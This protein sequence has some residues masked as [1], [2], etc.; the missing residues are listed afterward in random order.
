MAR[1]YLDHASSSPLRPVALEA[2]LPYLR[3]H[4]ADPGRLHAEG[5]ATRVAVEAA[6]EQVAALLRRPAARGRVHRER[7]RGGEHR[8]VG[9]AGARRG[10]RDTSSPPRSSTRRCSTRCARGADRGDRASAS[11]GSVASIPTRS[12]AAIRRRHRAGVGAA[13]QPRGRHAATGGRGG[14]G[15]PGPAASSC[16]STPARRPVTSPVDFAG[17][18]A[19]LCSVTGH[20]LGGPKGAAALLVRRGLR[21]PPFVVGGAQER[22]RRAGIENVPAIV[23]FGAAAAELARRRPT[24][25]PSRAHAH[26]RDSRATRSRA[27]PA[28]SASATRPTASP[29]SCASASTA[30]RPSRS[31]SR[32]TSAAWRCTPVRRARARRSSR[33][34][35]SRRWASTPTARLRASVGWSST[36]ADVDAFARRVPESSSNRSRGLRASVSCR[37]MTTDTTGP[38]SPPTLTDVLAPRRRRRSRSP[39][40]TRPS[41][42]RRDVRRADARRR[43]PTAAPA[44]CPPAA[45][46]G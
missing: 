12:S 28:S 11:T 20:K 2:M 41:R 22:A 42:R 23:G 24:T 34:R 15:R 18:G 45:C 3:D 4:H 39:S 31:C 1:A 30:S 33:R 7:H 43:S 13:R 9:R 6:R 25:R 5:H 37:A 8:G 46:S 14:R 16:T 36:D 44:A 29:T 21:F 32:S 26:G 17:L 19:D 38:T 27:C 35:C 40:P 10:G